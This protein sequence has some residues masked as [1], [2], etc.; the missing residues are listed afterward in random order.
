MFNNTLNLIK[1][2]L[3]PF[4]KILDSFDGINMQEHLNEMLCFVGISDYKTGEVCV[5]ISGNRFFAV[6][7]SVC[8]DI[9]AER[10]MT[11]SQLVTVADEAFVKTLST[12]GI[13]L[14]SIERKNCEF[15]KSHSR[16]KVSVLLELE[17]KL[18]LPSLNSAPVLINGNLEPSLQSYRIAGAS[19]TACTPLI[20]NAMLSN[21]VCPMPVKIVLSGFVPFAE[22]D[23][24]YSRYNSLSNVRVPINIG[25]NTFNNMLLTGVDISRKSESVC[26]VSLEFTEVNE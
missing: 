18:S 11:A 12:V 19:K 3:S 5:G 7:L 24:A 6:K 4:C 13:D 21:P 17:D 23:A 22:A 8:V 26:S 1:T 25:A 14:V 20:N 16:Y 9:L 2:S 10:T 15:S